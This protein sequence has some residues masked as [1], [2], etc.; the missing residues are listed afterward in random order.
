MLNPLCIMINNSMH[1]YVSMFTAVKCAYSNVYRVIRR[2][3]TPA[4]YGMPPNVYSSTKK[5]VSTVMN[6]KSN[7]YGSKETV[8]EFSCSSSMS[9]LH[10]TRVLYADNNKLSVYRVII[11]RLRFPV[12][13]SLSCLSARGTITEHLSWEERVYEL[14]HRYP[15]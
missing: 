2:L 7:V 11:I 1:L 4:L 8:T 10:Q 15:R 5:H 6:V 9:I 14:S 13:P 12:S 3:K